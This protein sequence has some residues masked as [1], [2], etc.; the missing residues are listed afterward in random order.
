[1]WPPPE[2]P[3]QSTTASVLQLLLFVDQRSTNNEQIQHV[4]P[5]LETLRADYA[6]NLQVIEVAE[7]PYLAEYYKLVAT[8][9]LVR[10]YPEPRQVLAGTNLVSQLQQCWSQWQ[11]VLAAT[12]KSV[13]NASLDGS[14]NAL[15]HSVQ[16]MQLTD[17]I[18]QL[19]QE[20]EALQEQVKFK[21]RIMAMLAHDLRSPLTAAIIA[22]E[23]L[24]GQ[25]DF[26]NPISTQLSPDMLLRLAQQARYQAQVIDRMITN[27][28]E[29]SRGDGA[30]LQ[31]RP[32]K[33]DLG[34]LCKQVIVD[35]ESKL[36]AKSQ[37]VTTDIPPDLPRVY[38]DADQVRQVLLNL[39][40]NANKYTPVGGRIQLAILHRTA[41][42]VQVSVCDSGLGIPEDMQVS[43]FE[44]HVRLSRDQGQEGYG[45]GLALCQRIVQAHYGQ[46]WVNSIPKQGSGFHFTLPVYR[47]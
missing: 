2:T 47:T 18:F 30:S 28:L 6:F 22:L 10:I 16:L 41:Q 37:T 35:I 26:E 32:K 14:Q 44:D 31:I 43:I 12:L 13:P 27:L 34:A 9:A 45:I 1:M 24:E 21:E 25:W 29:T 20:N 36:T 3:F 23:T 42:K 8:P 39:L 5:Y 11:Q 7:H 17:E 19:H 38:A 40:D 33:L 46:I 15:A 4:E